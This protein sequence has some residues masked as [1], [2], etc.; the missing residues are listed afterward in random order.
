MKLKSLPLFFL[1][2]TV[3]FLGVFLALSSTTVQAAMSKNV[4]KLQGSVFGNRSEAVNVTGEVIIY[5]ADRQEVFNFVADL[6][7]DHLW[8]PGT[9]SSELV[10]GDGGNGSVWQEYIFFGEGLFPIRATLMGTVPGS[11][12]WFT[13]DGILPNLTHYH[14]RDGANGEV[15]MTLQ[16]QVVLPEGV[17]KEFMEQYLFLTFQNLLGVLGEEGEVHVPPQQ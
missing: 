14:L 13:S 10:E 2:G 3:V 16:S 9:I 7:N 15:I 12:V 8:W 6:G 11:H 5:N 17:T 1:A 4:M